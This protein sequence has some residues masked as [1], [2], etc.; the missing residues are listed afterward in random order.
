MEPGLP[1]VRALPIAGHPCRRRSRHPRRLLSPEPERGRP[2]RALRPPRLHRRARALPSP[3]PRAAADPAGGRAL[4]RGGAARVAEAARA[5]GRG[6]LRGTGWRAGDW[7]PPT[8][9]TKEALDRVTGDTPAALMARDYHSLWLNSA[10][11][12]RA[13][14][15]SRC[16]RCRRAR[17]ARRADR[18]A[19][20]G[21]RVAFRDAARAAHRGRDGRGPPRRRAARGHARRDGGPRQGRLARRPRRLAAAP[22]RRRADL[23]VWQS[24][25]AEQVD[26]L[27]AL[28][29]RAASATTSFASAT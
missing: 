4:A 23:R 16:R 11:L 21:V 15:T 28:C 25:P 14:G 19:A 20:R 9:P 6:W 8:E 22:R 7:Q 2:R 17:R 1:I 27:E 29:I 12:A 3:G 10:A 26:E 5:A 24:I 13:D 18:G